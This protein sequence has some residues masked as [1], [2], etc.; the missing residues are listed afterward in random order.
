MED[1][2]KWLNGKRDAASGVAL[3]KKYEHPDAHFAFRLSDGLHTSK[4]FHAVKNL[5]DLGTDREQEKEPLPEV[6]QKN[7]QPETLTDIAQQAKKE[8]DLLFKQM[9]NKRAV[10]FAMVDVKGKAFENDGLRIKERSTLVNEVMALE[11]KVNVAYDNY[12]FALQ[13]GRLPVATPKPT[14]AESF[15]YHRIS[16]IRKNLSKYRNKKGALSAEQMQRMQQ[17][18]LELKDLLKQYDELD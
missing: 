11:Q 17:Y 2:V 10:L 6:A 13:N 15:L 12:R 16:N 3:L 18:E 7:P 14:V 4:I 8:A 1:V 9:Q 5:L